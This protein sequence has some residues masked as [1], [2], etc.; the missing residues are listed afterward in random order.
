MS[1]P[2]YTQKNPKGRKR[3]GSYSQSSAKSRPTSSF[4]MYRSPDSGTIGPSRFNTKLRYA[5]QK[6]FPI[7]LASPNAP[8]I[9]FAGNG[10]YDPDLQVGGQQPTGFDQ[11]MAMYLAYRVNACSMKYSVTVVPTGT[12]QVAQAAPFIPFQFSSTARM[13]LAG[14]TNS[15]PS[16]VCAPFTKTIVLSCQN[17]TRVMK[18]YVS[19]KSLVPTP[20]R[21]DI[22]FAGS[23]TANP[24]RVMNFDL[25]ASSGS[26]SWPLN[27]TDT[28]I[29]NVIVEMKFYCEFFTGRNLSIS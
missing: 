12:T 1:Q 13:L 19:M 15:W 14:S 23:S 27:A 8:I 3:S 10:L 5:S 17:G 7:T 24:V 28:M 4:K 6:S 18:H 16:T 26:D 11:L 29:V 25:N 22:E 21:K 20:E 9:T 2:P